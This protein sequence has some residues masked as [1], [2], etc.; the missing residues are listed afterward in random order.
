ME[1]RLHPPHAQNWPY[2]LWIAHRGGGDLAPENPL[3]AFRLG[4]AHGHRMTECDAKLSADGVVFLLHDDTLE[5]TSNGHGVAGNQTWAALSQL[6]A[7]GWHSPTHAGE[8]L[9]TLANIARF[10]QANGL[11]LNIEIKPTTGLEAETGRAV[12]L[13]AQALWADQEAHWAPLLS[14]FQPECLASARDAAPALRRGL[15]VE[16]LWEG[17]AHTATALGCVALVAEHPLWTPS[18]LETARAL[19]LRAL[20]YTANDDHDVDR[21]LRLGL[22]GIITDRVERFAPKR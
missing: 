12:A 17:W 16:E 15:L 2:P 13:A 10:C 8:P 1:P 5:R 19:G 6:D 21:L 7:G 18:L 9:P 4:A 3:A 11:W 22:D 14:S 20:A